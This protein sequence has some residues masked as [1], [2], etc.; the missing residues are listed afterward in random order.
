MLLLIIL[1]DPSVLR[2]CRVSVAFTRL[3]SRVGAAFYAVSL[4]VFR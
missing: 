1:I 2:P 4:S 3:P